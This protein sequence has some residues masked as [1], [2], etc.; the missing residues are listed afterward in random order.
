M[1]LPHHGLMHVHLS[2]SAGTRTDKFG[3][4]PAAVE[5]ILYSW[6]SL[7]E[8]P[9]DLSRAVRTRR[10]GAVRRRRWRHLDI[11]RGTLFDAEQYKP[12]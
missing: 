4:V 8:F 2:E 10:R 1:G 9:A 5:P 3:W 12:R 6:G 11:D 7:D